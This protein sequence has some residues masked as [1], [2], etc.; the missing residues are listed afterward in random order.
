MKQKV[1]LIVGCLLT[2]VFAGSA[3]EVVSLKS[4]FV[5]KKQGLFGKE[6]VEK[7]AAPAVTVRS[8][9][10]AQI[11]I[12]QQLVPF[13]VPLPADVDGRSFKAFSGLQLTV[14]PVLKGGVI[15]VWGKLDYSESIQGASPKSKSEQGKGGET[16]EDFVIRQDV[17]F[18]HGAFKKAGEK[19]RWSWPVPGR[20]GESYEIEI[21]PSLP[22]AP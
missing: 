8:G 5:L 9:Q 22:K 7:L 13:K 11:A 15:D 4:S 14:L 10:E 20:K 3:Q 21:E 1:I 17:F 2:T 12:G 6:K 16:A 18:F 19:L